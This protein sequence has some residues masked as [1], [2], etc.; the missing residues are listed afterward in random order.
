MST[1]A[2]VALAAA[3]DVKADLPGVAGAIPEVETFAAAWN[4]R[5]GA[6][7]ERRVAQRIYKLTELRPPV[8]VPGGPR[9]ATESDRELLISWFALSQRKPTPPECRRA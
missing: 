3:I 8:D 9:E 1:D 2:L 6:V 5:T 4:S 7:I